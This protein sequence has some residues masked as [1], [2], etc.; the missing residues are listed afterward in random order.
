M[1]VGQYKPHG[2]V[3]YAREIVRC[4]IF[5]VWMKKVN[6]EEQKKPKKKK[7]VIVKDNLPKV[8]YIIE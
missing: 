6:E 5:E 2:E 4:G 7:I 8:S 1:V 3:M